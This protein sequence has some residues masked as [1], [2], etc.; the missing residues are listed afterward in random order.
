MSNRTVNTIASGRIM[1]AHQPHFLPWL[2]YLDK[3]RRSDVFVLVDHVQYERQNFQNRN[4][5]KTHQGAQ[6]VIVPVHQVTRAEC[7]CDK[8]VNNQRD[9]RTTWG[10]RIF[11]SLECAYGKAPHFDTYAPRLQAILT[12][13]WDKLVDLDEALLRFFMEAF[14]IATPLVRSSTLG[15]SGTKSDMI[16]AMCREVGA[17]TYLSGSGGSRGYLDCELFERNGLRVAWQTFRHPGYPQRS[18]P[19]EF[20]PRLAA[21][22]MLFNCGPASA[23]LLREETPSAAVSEVALAGGAPAS[24]EPQLLA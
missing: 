14:E 9:G 1:A 21:V 5:I 7:I 2:G 8:R 24:P 6:W 17:Q 22:D 3:V 18:P 4:R 11:R 13:P 10:Q 12:R 23:A 20:V 19:A 15:V 16:I